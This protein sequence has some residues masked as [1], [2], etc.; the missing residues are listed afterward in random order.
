MGLNSSLTPAVISDEAAGVRNM[1][2][3]SRGP[4]RR[5]VDETHDR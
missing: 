2:T 4:S 1:K 5:M 3:K